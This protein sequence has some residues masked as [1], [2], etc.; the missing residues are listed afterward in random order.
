MATHGD[1]PQ[2]AYPR[3]RKLIPR[4]LHPVIR[5]VRKYLQRRKL[6]L[7]EPFHTVFP[8]TQA[9][10]IRQQNILR[11]AETIDRENVPGAALECGV[12]DGG[13]SALIASGTTR[14][15]RALHMFDAW[16]GLPPA[17]AEDG[18][19]GEKWVGDVVGSKGRVEQVMR[20]LK[21]DPAR[22]NYHV[23]WFH[24]TFPTADVPTVALLH[25]D[26][27]FYDPTKL[28]LER[29]YGH[30]APGGFVQ[31]DDYGI[32]IGCTKAVDEFLVQ[33]PELRLE[34]APSP[35]GNAYYFR[36]PLA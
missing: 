31:I 35:Q 8:F 25:V 26:C 27:D 17:T 29:W 30:L 7:P 23:G 28:C 11:L 33:H 5:G 15:G 1:A 9:L 18:K 16:R 3:L 20:L 34:F 4:R 6:S 10:M 22:L 32:F 24:E 36:K 14:S 19:G 12:L 21:I 2:Q 13:M